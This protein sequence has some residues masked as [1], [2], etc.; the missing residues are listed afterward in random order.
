MPLNQIFFIHL[1]PKDP[2]TQKFLQYDDSKNM[3]FPHNEVKKSP[4]TPEIST[5]KA[6]SKSSPFTFLKQ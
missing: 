1:N 6:F 2:K 3:H 5:M 4:K